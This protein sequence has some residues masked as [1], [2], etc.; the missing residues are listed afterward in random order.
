MVIAMLTI[1]T[2]VVTFLWARR[3]PPGPQVPPLEAA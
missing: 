3:V 1:M 2:L